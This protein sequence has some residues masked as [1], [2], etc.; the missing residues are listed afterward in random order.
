MNRKERDRIVPETIRALCKA[1][2]AEAYIRFFGGQVYPCRALTVYQERALVLALTEER[3]HLGSLLTDALWFDR[4]VSLL[5]RAGEQEAAL[6]ASVYR[7][8]I[9]GPLFAGMLSWL[10]AG[11]PEADIASAWELRPLG[12]A[13]PF[14]L[15]GLRRTEAAIEPELHL[16]HPS[17]PRENKI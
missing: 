2:E 13:E 1:P 3:T 7:C 4:P 17:F 9:A 15:E 12:L 14:S 6:E 11:D 10:R 5:I 16:D 8:H